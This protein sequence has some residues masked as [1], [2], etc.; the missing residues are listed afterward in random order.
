[1]RTYHIPANVGQVSHV[2]F[3]V[4]V[5]QS[6]GRWSVAYDTTKA[7]N[8]IFSTLEKAKKSEASYLRA[9][10]RKGYAPVTRIVQAQ[11]TTT[12]QVV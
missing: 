5:E 7:G 12:F 11:T 2:E 1:M 9:M 8:A 6:D 4:Q 3:Q 10:K